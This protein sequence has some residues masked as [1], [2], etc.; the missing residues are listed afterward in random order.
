MPDRQRQDPERRPTSAVLYDHER[1]TAQEAA[2]VA[3]RAEGCTC[4]PEV[5]IAGVSAF[6][7]HDSWCSLL[8]RRD[9]N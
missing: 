7:R 2:I 4:A 6:L 1:I 5:T 3:A 9:V 8:R